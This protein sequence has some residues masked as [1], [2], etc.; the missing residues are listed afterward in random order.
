MFSSGSG[1]VFSCIQRSAASMVACVKPGYKSSSL[2]DSSGS[3]RTS[4]STSGL[5]EPT[6]WTDSSVDSED[7]LESALV[8]VT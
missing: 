1:S 7:C 8:L 3:L 4:P 5:D 2:L 6:Y